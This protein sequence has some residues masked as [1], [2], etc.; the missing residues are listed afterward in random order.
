MLPVAGRELERL[1]LSCRQLALRLEEAEQNL[2]RLRQQGAGAVPL[3]RRVNIRFANVQD[4][5]LRLKL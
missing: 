1:A 4:D 3:V 5:A 2:A